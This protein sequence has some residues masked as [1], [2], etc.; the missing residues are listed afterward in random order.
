MRCAISGEE[1]TEPV[2]SSKSGHIFEKKLVVNYIST[3]GRDPI[4]DEPLTVD[5]LIPIN[6][7][8]SSITPA[9]PPTFNSIPSLLSTFQNEWD[10]LA[11]EVFTLRKQ[12][13]KA[14]EELSAALYHHDAAV[15]VAAKAIKERDEAKQ[16]LQDLSVAIGKAE[17]LPTNNQT[18][19]NETETTIPYAEEL[20]QAREQLFQIHKS[21]KPTLPLTPDQE[22]SIEFG[23]KHFQPFKSI[24][25][26]HIDLE[27]KTILMASDTNRIS[28]CNFEDPSNPQESKLDWKKKGIHS[29]GL[30]K[31]NGKPTPVIG[32]MHQLITDRNEIIQEVRPD[33][34]ISKIVTHPK[35]SE[36]FITTEANGKWFLNKENQNVFQS[37]NDLENT[38]SSLHVDGILLAV[39]S[40]DGIRLFNIIDG[41]ENLKLDYPNASNIKFAMNGYWLLASSGN[42]LDVFDLRK[43]QIAHSIVLDHKIVDFAIDPSSSVIITYDDSHTLFLHR[44]IKKGKQWVDKVFEKHVTEVKKPL[45]TIDSWSA[46]EDQSFKDDGIVTF[47]AVAENSLILDFQLKYN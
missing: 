6:S 45:K 12:L 17:P 35:L 38:S 23:G 32:H 30:I 15:R 40:P 14:R 3:S 18:T 27:S 33:S 36:Y 5:D 47:K 28:L 44:Y 22:V 29:L 41:S 7:E 16:S 2:I 31:H 39:A 42:S 13:F 21:Q 1:A 43:N 26:V 10:S 25:K 8:L 34:S 9:K 37:P 11:L 46:A 20:E 24:Q 4:N 19:S